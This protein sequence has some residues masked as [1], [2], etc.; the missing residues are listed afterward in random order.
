MNIS[1]FIAF[2][3]V[4]IFIALAWRLLLPLLGICIGL[5]LWYLLFVFVMGVMQGVKE[6]AKNESEGA[7]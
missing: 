7:K 6:I 4:L 3:L 5:L 2:M 1:H